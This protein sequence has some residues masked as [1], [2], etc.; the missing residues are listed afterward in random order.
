[1][2]K[3]FLFNGSLLEGIIDIAANISI[4]IKRN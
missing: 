3:R 4:D 2:K 1:M